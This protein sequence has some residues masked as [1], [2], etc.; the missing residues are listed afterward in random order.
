MVSK[1]KGEEFMPPLPMLAVHHGSLK[2]STGVLKNSKK[3]M[4]PTFIAFTSSIY[5][6]P[7]HLSSTK[8]PTEVLTQNFDMKNLRMQLS[9]PSFVLPRSMPFCIWNYVWQILQI[10]IILAGLCHSVTHINLPSKSTDRLFSALWIQNYNLWRETDCSYLPIPSFPQ[11]H[12]FGVADMGPRPH[13]SE[14]M[15][16]HDFQT[17]KSALSYRVYWL[18]QK[19][20]GGGL[21]FTA[22]VK[23]NVILWKRSQKTMVQSKWKSRSMSL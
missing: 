11:F 7:S 8:L 19:T 22:S 14:R 6:L 20:G 13:L 17:L 15:W 16:V 12:R 3:A 18:W 2:V 9:R 10:A 4:Q 1:Q 5:K 23:Q 21:L